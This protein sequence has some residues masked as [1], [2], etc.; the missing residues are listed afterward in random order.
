M[1]IWTKSFWKA[2][3]ERVLW[4]L[5]QIAIGFG[6]AFI[7][8]G[9]TF[10]GWDWKNTLLAISVSTVTAMLKGIGANAVTKNGPGTA[11]SEQVQPSLPNIPAS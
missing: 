4:T 7:Q 1:T 6:T 9:M 11:S 10:E 2:W 3:A 8:N 5:A